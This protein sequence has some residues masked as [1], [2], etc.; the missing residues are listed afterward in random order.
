MKKFYI[1]F[2]EN[3]PSDIPFEEI[4]E[5]IFSHFP[6]NWNF[7]KQH[8]QRM[9]FIEKI[10]FRASFP[11]LPEPFLLLPSLKE[12]EFL[13]PKDCFILYKVPEKITLKG[14]FQTFDPKPF[15]DYFPEEKRLCLSKEKLLCPLRQRYLTEILSDLRIL[16]FRNLK[17]TSLKIFS[18]FPKLEEVIFEKVSF[19]LSKEEIPS[20]KL[21]RL[22]ILS[23]QN[24]PK[25][26]L[27][28]QAN[29][30]VLENFNE[31]IPISG[32]F[33]HLILKNS[34]LDIDQEKR[35]GKQVIY[36]TIGKLTLEDYSHFPNFSFPDLKNLEIRFPISNFLFLQKFPWLS[37]LEF[38]SSIE[39]L[40]LSQ[41]EIWL[42]RDIQ[43]LK[44]SHPSFLPILSQLSDSKVGF[45][46][47]LQRISFFEFLPSLSKFSVFRFIDCLE[48][49]LFE[50][51]LRFFQ[52]EKKSPFGKKRVEFVQEQKK[53]PL[54]NKKFYKLLK[55]G[56]K[57][58][59]F[60]KFNV[61]TFSFECSDF[62]FSLLNK[63]Q[64]K[65]YKLLCLFSKSLSFERISNF[66]LFDTNAT[67]I[68]IRNCG[69]KRVD[70]E[71]F[72]SNL[73]SLDLS[74]NQIFTFDPQIFKIHSLRFLSLR[75]NQIRSLLPGRF[76]QMLN[77]DLRENPLIVETE[78][79]QQ[80]KPQL[81]TLQKEIVQI[82]GIF[83]PH[84][85][86]FLYCGHLYKTKQIKT[87]KILNFGSKE[88]LLTCSKCGEKIKY[89]D[90][91][92]ELKKIFGDPEL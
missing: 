13:G 39:N 2:K 63:E 76:Y 53:F 25:F 6:L 90:A 56:S 36:R 22:Q 70:W 82:S 46:L 42:F 17:I 69:L 85:E 47:S 9:K 74:K 23:C 89:R 40:K 72:P 84:D 45:S 34:F 43:I 71:M 68:K 62:D 15:G 4:N 79:V 31:P 5:I 58:S 26:P 32:Y 41:K 44:I 30:L 24:V 59:L 38:S 64:K 81:L 7:S 86:G 83:S 75:K 18:F 55:Y 11:F 33:N 12:I 77:L 49:N 51:C 52:K 78:I 21:Q 28:F 65:F 57:I 27:L 16:H 1:D 61:E 8:F 29:I 48:P 20:K 73:R 91:P 67:Q 66:F 54:S 88:P 50:K 19:S 35:E 92:P 14:N 80:L 37:S 10:T 87:K 3:F 60:G